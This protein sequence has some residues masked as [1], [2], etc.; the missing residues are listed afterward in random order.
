MYIEEKIGI[1]LIVLATIGAL[2]FPAFAVTEYTG[3]PMNATLEQVISFTISNELT[4]GIFFTGEVI[5]STTYGTQYNLTSMTAWANATYNYGPIGT[6]YNATMFNMT[7]GGNTINI[8]M[9]QCPCNHLLCQS[10]TCIVGTDFLYVNNT[11]SEGVKWINGTNRFPA[12]S[13]TYWFTY[14]GGTDDMTL[15]GGRVDANNV[16]HMRYWLNPYP[17]TE[18]SG[19]YNTTFNVKILEYGKTAPTCAC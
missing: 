4:A 16:I 7:A 8:T 11:N 19:I 13:G 1:G 17:D 10:G 6:T 2:L 9:Y 14:T 12:D 18:P 15:V 5:N 3:Q